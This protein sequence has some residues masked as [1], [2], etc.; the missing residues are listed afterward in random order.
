[1]YTCGKTKIKRQLVYLEPIDRLYTSKK[2]FFS[3]KF[4][5]KS[6]LLDSD[7]PEKDFHKVVC[8]EDLYFSRGL[9]CLIIVQSFRFFKR[10]LLCTNA[11]HYLLLYSNNANECFHLL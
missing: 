1:M 2:S 7:F 9:R 6:D 5:D 10:A 8:N 3:Y 11:M 4:F